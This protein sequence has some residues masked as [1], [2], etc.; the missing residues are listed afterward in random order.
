MPSSTFK[1]WISLS[2]GEFS[3]LFSVQGSSNVI[4]VY[5]F[6]NDLLHSFQLKNC[7]SNCK[8]YNEVTD[9]R[10]VPVCCK[11]GLLKCGKSAFS[12]S[13]KLIRLPFLFALVTTAERFKLQSRTVTHTFHIFT[14][15]KQ[16][17]LLQKE[18]S[19]K[20]CLAQ[21]LHPSPG[22]EGSRSQ[23]HT[24]LII[25]CWWVKSNE[26]P[27]MHPVTAESPYSCCVLMNAAFSE[28]TPVNTAAAITAFLQSH[29][30][31]A[32][33]GLCH[34]DPC[35]QLPLGKTHC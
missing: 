17:H 25:Q 6:N 20:L 1:E 28:N 31:M 5:L 8:W 4:E 16:I 7:P 27:K 10:I 13:G 19:L 35:L 26:H 21:N 30:P 22:T 2:R 23:M 14:F 15:R 33:E 3:I 18:N 24:T 12:F 11:F 9:H 34:P 32:G 29:Y